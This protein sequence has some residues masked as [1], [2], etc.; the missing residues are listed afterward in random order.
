MKVKDINEIRLSR[1][2]GTATVISSVVPPFYLPSVPSLFGRGHGP[3]RFIIVNIAMGTLYTAVFCVNYF[4]L[5]PKFLIR[6]ER[7]FLYFL[8]NFL[9]IVALCSI[10]PLIMEM[11]ESLLG[12][13][14]HRHIHQPDTARLIMGYLRFLVRDGVMMILAAG[15]A[16]ALRLSNERERMRRRELELN[17]ERRQIELQSLKAQLNPHFLFNSLNNIYA[18]IGFAPEK[19]Q[20][21]LHELSGMLRFMIYDST[22]PTVALS[23]ELQFIREYVDLMRLRLNSNVVLTCDVFHPSDDSLHIAPLMFLTLV[24]NAFKHVSS[25]GK[26]SFITILIRPDG[27][28]LQAEII[29]SCMPEADNSPKDSASGVGLDNIRRQ[30]SLIYP[31]KHSLTTISNYGT[32][33]AD[34]KISMKAL[35]RES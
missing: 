27:D 26:G 24:E 10:V 15:L 21:A 35:K 31:G 6:S 29:N 32:F 16:Y 14:R 3:D 25:N 18:L 33:K 22:S 34:L 17:A 5:V 7:K 13:R 11:N 20:T 12:L 2:G 23:K 19:A 8:I 1:F 9:M 4:W 28:D 30:L